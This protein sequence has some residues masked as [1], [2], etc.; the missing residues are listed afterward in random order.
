MK[1]TIKVNE[2]IYHKD[3][4]PAECITTNRECKTYAVSLNAIEILPRIFP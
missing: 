1:F 4:L 3:P 2:E